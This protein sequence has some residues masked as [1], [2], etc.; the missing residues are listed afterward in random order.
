MWEWWFFSCLAAFATW[1]FLAQN[2]ASKL[3]VPGTSPRVIVYLM[4]L[5]RLLLAI[6]VL[7]IGYILEPMLRTVM[8]LG[9]GQAIES[10]GAGA[11]TQFMVALFSAMVPASIATVVANEG[12]DLKEKIQK[13]A[14]TA[15]ISLVIL[16]TVWNF[17]AIRPFADYLFSLFSDLIGGAIAGALIGYAAQ[18]AQDKQAALAGPGQLERRRTDTA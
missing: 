14:I 13:G 2:E 6:A 1:L 3:S 16:D 5:A 12:K 7:T 10:L 11:F 4:S 18:M 9:P 15:V 17:I 8:E